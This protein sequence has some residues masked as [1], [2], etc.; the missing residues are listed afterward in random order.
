M[1]WFAIAVGGFAVWMAVVVFFVAL[2]SAASRS[3]R[4]ANARSAPATS[5]VID[6]SA[7]RPF[8]ERRDGEPAARV[9]ALG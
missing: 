8:R 4:R 1:V 3:E 9:S 6:L 7:F 5:A 2:C